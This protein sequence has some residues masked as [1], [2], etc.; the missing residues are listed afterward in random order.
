[1]DDYTPSNFN[2][3]G[4][5]TARRREKEI[6]EFSTITLCA[7]KLDASEYGTFGTTTVVRQN[8]PSDLVYEM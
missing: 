8:S 4:V 3:D 5:Y 7:L 6:I 1:M 2:I